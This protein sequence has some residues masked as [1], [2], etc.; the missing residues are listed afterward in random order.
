V[1]LHELA[2]A[3]VA[4][5]HGVPVGAITLHVFGGVSQLEGEPE[6]PRA[7][8]RIA[9]VGPLMSLALAAVAWGI[10]LMVAGASWADALTGYLAAVNLVVALFNLVPAFPL[11]GGR[12]LRAGLWAWSG[13]SDRATV[14]ASQVGLALALLMVALGLA[15]ALTGETMAGLWLALIGL[16]LYQAAR[17]SYDLARVQARLERL[18]VAQVMSAAP[19]ALHA[20]GSPVRTV[21]PGDSAWQAF[22]AVTRSGHAP[23]AVVD[24]GALVGV[25]TQRDLQPL[26]LADRRRPGAARG[27]GRAA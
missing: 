9:I 8:L 1:L 23:V 11:D 26:V 15:R 3:L 25:V 27:A 5:R 19:V 18:R 20:A 4:V 13:R 2:H 12:I 10:G 22:L 6:T 14:V 24:D 7:E 16:F 21:A 17:A